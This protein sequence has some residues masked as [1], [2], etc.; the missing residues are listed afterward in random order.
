MKHL[1]VTDIQNVWPPEVKR[2]DD[3]DKALPTIKHLAINNVMTDCCGAVEAAADWSCVDLPCHLEVLCLL[4]GPEAAT[5]G[6]EVAV[7]QEE[8]K[9]ESDREEK[10][11]R[12]LMH[13]SATSSEL[14]R[15]TEFNTKSSKV[16]GVLHRGKNTT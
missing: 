10:W 14:F 16:C 2:S 9:D 1:N 13:T 7:E 5:A 8:K 15:K 3:E 6:E 4:S 12:M 11:N